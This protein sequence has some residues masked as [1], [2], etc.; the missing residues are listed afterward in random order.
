MEKK[1]HIKEES[2]EAAETLCGC[3]FVWSHLVELLPQK[4]PLFG[5]VFAE[6]LLVSDE[7]S[8]FADGTVQ[9][10]LRAHLH[11]LTE[12]LGLG[13]QDFPGLSDTSKGKRDAQKRKQYIYKSDLF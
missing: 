13:D 10:I 2:S 8:Q 6:L 7:Q 4:C 1:C 3:V 9:Q 5:V 12:R 11:Q